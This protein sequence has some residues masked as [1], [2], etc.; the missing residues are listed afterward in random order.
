MRCCACAAA[1]QL[2]GILQHLVLRADI[3]SITLVLVLDLLKDLIRRLR[4]ARRH[5]A[6][7]PVW[8]AKKDSRNIFIRQLIEAP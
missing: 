1:A 7:K 3:L 2:Q 4:D 8:V 5:P 6:S